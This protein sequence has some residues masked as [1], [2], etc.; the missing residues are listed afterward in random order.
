MKNYTTSTIIIFFSS[1]CLVNM[2]SG[3]NRK[4]IPGYIITN[5]GDTLNGFIKNMAKRRMSNTIIFKKKLAEDEE[6]Y[7]PNDIQAFFHEPNLH[8]KALEIRLGE[9]KKN[10]FL[11]K[12]VE[13]YASLYKYDGNT[14]P[15]FVLQQP[16]YDLVQLE[17]VTNLDQ[18]NLKED[19]KYI[20]QVKYF[21]KSCPE[22]LNYLDYFTFNSNNLGK[23]IT[24]YNKCV[25][26][27][28]QT[29]TY[30]NTAIKISVGPAIDFLPIT[31]SGEFA[32]AFGNKNKTTNTTMRYGIIGDFQI[33]DWLDIQLGAQ[34]VRYTP[35]FELEFSLG[36][37][38]YDY[39][40]SNIDLPIVAKY[41]L[42]NGE[43]VPYLMTGL[44]FGIPVSANLKRRK[45]VG[46]ELDEEMESPANL[47][48]SF[49]YTGGVGIKKVLGTFLTLDANISYNGSSFILDRV[50]DDLRMNGVV[51]RIGLL[52]RI[53]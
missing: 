21:I 28:L 49:G 36:Q 13:G 25:S 53:N 4:L 45:Y 16:N 42:S 19:R 32:E 43:L 41:K 33:T 47:V 8:Y 38:L 52:F 44:V 10:K 14:N 6:S 24:K 46:E 34:Y 51:G 27:E 18:N 22:A 31:M 20:G 39:D 11:R 9:N 23:I 7:S 35:S 30:K 1:F 3:Q 40:L 12:L 5:E 48:L 15:I 50:N 2:C 26:P 29:Q 17:K 37:I